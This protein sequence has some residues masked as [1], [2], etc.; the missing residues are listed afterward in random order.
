MID[1]LVKKF[2]KNY[3]DIGNNRVRTA[4]GVLASCVGIACNV[5][6]FGLKLAVGLAVHSV[7]VISDAFNNLSDAASSVISFIGVKMASR[8]ADKEHPFGHGRLEYIAALVVAFLVVEVGFSLFKSSIDKIFHPEALTFSLISVLILTASITVKLWMSFF[9]R[10]LGNRINS[11]VMKATAADSLGDVITTSATILSLAVYG[12]WRINIDGIV[13]LI[14][15]VVVMI[16]GINIARDTLAPLLGEA[17]SPE[18]SSR[19]T[20][21]VESYEGIIGTHDLIVHNYGPAKSM[22]SIH[23]EV[24]TNVNIERSHEIID[25]IERDAITSLGIFLVIHMDPVAVDDEKL[26]HYKSIVEEVI[27]SLG[28]KYSLHDFRMVNGEKRINLIYDLVIPTD[29][30]SRQS[31]ELSLLINRMVQEKDP[32]CCCVITVEK[33]FCAN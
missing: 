12:I 25:R 28:P 19:I 20:E 7:S 1:F 8:P 13:G 29:Y 22:A 9:N 2:V 11:S 31:K 10:R 32:S 17:V 33:S 21:F 24:P 30:P 26:I 15:S 16:A 5:F 3:E 23:A 4:Y 6:L 18:V 14:V 27:Q